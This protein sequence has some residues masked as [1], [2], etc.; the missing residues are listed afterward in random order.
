[1]SLK[2]N[3]K[4][5]HYFAL[6]PSHDNVNNIVDN[7]KH[8]I[9]NIKTLETNQ[10]NLLLLYVNFLS[11]SDYSKRKIDTLETIT[12]LKHFSMKVTCPP[13]PKDKD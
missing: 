2:L 11:W 6:F 4:I 5:Q 13:P 7:I 9:N 10:S 3:H 12:S 1:M 8:N